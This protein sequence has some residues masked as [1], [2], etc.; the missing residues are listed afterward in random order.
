MENSKVY[1]GGVFLDEEE[2]RDNKIENKVE[3]EYYSIKK[4]SYLKEDKATYGIEVVKKEYKER[5]MDVETSSVHNICS[6]QSQINEVIELLKR[7]TVTPN[8][9]HVT[10]EELMKQGLV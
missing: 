1:Y 2:L 10:M 8:G 7:N 5:D 6:N 3:L 4:P 9:L